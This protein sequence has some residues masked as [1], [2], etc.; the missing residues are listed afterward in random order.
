MSKTDKER[1][2]R[3]REKQKARGRKHISLILS[4]EA[5]DKLNRERDRTGE[6]IAQIINRL[7]L[8]LGEVASK[9]KIDVASKQELDVT[10]KRLPVASK[11]T[12]TKAK[13]LI[14]PEILEEVK[15]DPIDPEKQRKIDMVIELR[16]QGLSFQR[17]ADY[18]SK[19]GETTLSG[20]GTWRQG[21][22]GKILRKAGI[23]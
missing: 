1:F 7:L 18:M 21:A 12:E 17:I 23:D 22:V 16:A 5:T 15:A 19:Q 8:N 13:S 20:R 4:L 10:S 2:K 3:W 14:D 9:Q 6:S 11:R